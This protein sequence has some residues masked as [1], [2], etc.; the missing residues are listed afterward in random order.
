MDIPV[1]RRQHSNRALYR[2]YPTRRG[3]CNTIPHG[4]NAFA[5]P[6]AAPGHPHGIY[7]GYRTPGNICR[8][9]IYPGNGGATL[10]NPKRFTLTLIDDAHLTFRQHSRRIKVNLWRLIPYMSRISVRLTDP[11]RPKIS[12]D[13]SACF[14]AALRTRGAALS[15]I[16]NPVRAMKKDRHPSHA[17]S[18]CSSS[19]DT[20][21]TQHAK[22]HCNHVSRHIRRHRPTPSQSKA[23][24]YRPT[25][26]TITSY[27]K[28]LRSMR[29][30][31]FVTN[32]HR[33]MTM[34]S[35]ILQFTY[36]RHDNGAMLHSRTATIAAN[37]PPRDTPA[38]C[39]ILGPSIQ[40]LS[41]RHTHPATPSPKAVAYDTDIS[42][43]SCGV[44]PPIITVINTNTHLSTFNAFYT[45]AFPK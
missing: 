41:S 9:N 4:G 20:A 7:L 39:H 29:E 42:A 34:L 26:L 2:Q 14:P 23:T 18:R 17:C 21:T 35:I 24:A 11:M 22:D 3:R 36:R 19:M 40:L 25:A 28:P 45:I 43:I 33:S 37:I 32:N 44:R 10:R 8:R 27:D 38:I 6:V 31:F 15:V 13:V 5:M 30:T 16:H 12:T 1:R